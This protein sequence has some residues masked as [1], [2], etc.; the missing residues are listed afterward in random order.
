[1]KELKKIS[2]LDANENQTKSWF[3]EKELQEYAKEDVVVESVGYVVAKD[4]NSLVLASDVI[5]YEEG[6]ETQYGRPMKILRKNIVKIT[7]L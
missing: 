4:K 3:S 6:I 5:E 2:W 1:M 7:N